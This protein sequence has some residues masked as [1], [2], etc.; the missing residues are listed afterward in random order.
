M[1]ALAIMAVQSPACFWSA[2]NMTSLSA[3]H[4][5]CMVAVRAY[6]Q[7][8]IC[9]QR[10]KQAHARSGMLTHLVITYRVI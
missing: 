7:Q 9:V 4:E 6:A 1:C 2:L 8:Y 3:A 5:D 10:R